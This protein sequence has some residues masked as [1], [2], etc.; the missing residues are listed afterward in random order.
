MIVKWDMSVEPIATGGNVTTCWRAAAA[1][2]G[3]PYVFTAATP[4]AAVAG[5]AEE[6]E[7]LQVEA[8]DLAALQ[9]AVAKATTLDEAV[10]AVAAS[11]KSP[12][13][14]LDGELLVRVLA[15]SAY[16]KTMPAITNPDIVAATLARP[17]IVL[18]RERL[19]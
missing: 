6:M 2:S 3:T 12:S 15:H 16:P 11:L 8:K 5:L 17:G 18:K 10:V 14:R 7:N 19:G 4:S 13:S 9:A 1:L